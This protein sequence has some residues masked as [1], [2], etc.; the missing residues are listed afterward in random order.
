MKYIL[1]CSDS[2]QA[3]AREK[4]TVTAD[5]LDEAWEKA[6]R[7]FVRKFHTRKM[8]V[9]ITGV[10]RIGDVHALEGHGAAGGQL[11]QVETAQ[12]GGLSASRRTYYADNLTLIY[13]YVNSVQNMKLTEAFF[14]T[15]NYYLLI[16]H[17]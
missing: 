9:A 4:M 7:R 15:L 2:I 1:T 12:K 8:Y 6:R 17:N 11:Q 3:M 14:Q 5:T 13:R 10:E 16:F